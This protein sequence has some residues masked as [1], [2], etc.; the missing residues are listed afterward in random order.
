MCV[1]IVYNYRHN[2]HFLW[3]V[4]KLLIVEII[5]EIALHKLCFIKAVVAQW[6]ILTQN[7]QL[8]TSAYTIRTYI[9]KQFESV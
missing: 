5:I 9:D 8:Q 7:R 2:G 4:Y 6:T 3:Q 1:L